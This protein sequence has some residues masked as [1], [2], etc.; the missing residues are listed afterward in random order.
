MPRKGA[1]PYNGR[2]FSTVTRIE[3]ISKR[4]LF[5]RKFRIHRSPASP[6]SA[7]SEL[8]NKA[9]KIGFFA[10]EVQTSGSANSVL[11]DS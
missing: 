5:Y 11:Q 2:N 8:R 10:F 1:V 6:V 9:Q 3:V 7:K 4:K